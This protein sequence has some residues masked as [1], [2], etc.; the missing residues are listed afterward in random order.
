MANADRPRGFE[1][2]GNPLR[3]NAYESGS[4]CYPGDFVA[5]ASD[6]QV[7][8]VAAGAKILGLCLSYASAAGAEILVAD[9]P[10]Q[11]YVG[12]ADESDLNAQTDI[13]N[14]CDIVATGGNSTY[15]TSRQEVDSS[16][17]GASS[18]QLLILGIE[19]RP[20]NALGEFVDVVVRV[21]ESQMADSFAGV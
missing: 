9:H 17:V 19:N 8:P 2:K 10:D 16:T 14:C 3:V 1:C 20:N 7:D 13:G 5:L 12:Q 21:N 15:K 18:A 4:A 6:G 11:L